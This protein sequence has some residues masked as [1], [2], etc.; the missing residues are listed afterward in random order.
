MTELAI[1][2]P[3]FCER[4]NLAPLVRALGDVLQG[5]EYEI[6]FVDDDSPDDTAGA[7]RELARSDPR[8]RV[9]HRI[10]RRGLSSAVLEGMMSTGADYLAVMDGDMQHDEAAL[11]EML[12]RIRTG[13]LDLV[14]GTRNTS[15]GSMGEF[16]AGRVALSQL[17]RRLSAFTCKAELSDPMSGYFVV[18]RSYLLEV[19]HSLSAVGFKVLVDL[20]ASARRPVRIAEVGY[21]F[22]NRLRGESKLDLIVSLQYLELLLDKAIGNWVPVRYALFGMVGAVGVAAQFVLVWAFIRWSGYAFH[23]AQLY[24]SLL[25]IILNFTLNNHLTFRSSRLSGWR[26]FVGLGLFT[27][28]CSIGLLSNLRV[29]DTLRGLGLEWHLASVAGIVIG[30]VWN[31]GVSSML[32]WRRAR[33]GVLKSA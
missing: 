1:I 5:V 30:S 19:V 31:Y 32:V 8:I 23:E 4:D 27:A 13:T 33:E 21:T 2:V 9:L 22:R 11:P 20:V 10:K 15:G 29:A 16:S 18:T 6:I 24:A 3:T 14:I 12:R 7:A 17:G 26:W 25:V 28:A